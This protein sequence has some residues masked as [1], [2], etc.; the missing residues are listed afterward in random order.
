MNKYIIITIISVMLFV[1]PAAG[2][3]QLPDYNFDRHTNELMTNNFTLENLTSLGSAPYTDILG[4]V[5]WGLL[6]GILFVV[7]WISTEDITI[8]AIVGMLIGASIWGLMP[9]EW[10]QAAMS[11]TVV[12]FA[13]IVYSILKRG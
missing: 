1:S 2:I 8:P 3:S 6:F 9:G 7:M 10:T 5:F 4:S 12:S 13:G 11:L